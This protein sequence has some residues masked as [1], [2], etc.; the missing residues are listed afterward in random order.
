[1]R[2][3]AERAGLSV[4]IDSAGT[5]DWHVGNPPDRR[6]VAT[7]RRH[8]VD[9][10]GLRGRQ[11]RRADFDHFDKVVALDGKNHEDLCR[12]APAASPAEISLLLDHAPGRAGESVADPYFGQESGFESTWNDIMAGVDGLITELAAQPRR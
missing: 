6:A 11:V 10:A 4:E 5:G 9:I 2:A 8:G 1:M 7:A 3:A 12:L